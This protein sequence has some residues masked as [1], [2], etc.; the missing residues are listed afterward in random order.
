MAPIITCHNALTFMNLKR[1]QSR[2]TT[3]IIFS[4]FVCTAT[5][6]GER[7]ASRDTLS[8][9][10]P[11]A[12]SRIDIG[13]L[14]AAAVGPAQ[15]L[16]T[17]PGA[18]VLE[19]HVVAHGVGVAEAARARRQRAAWGGGGRGSVCGEMRARR[20]CAAQRLTARRASA[21]I[22]NAPPRYHR[23]PS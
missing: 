23:R 5:A 2:A 17:V 16:E 10:Q 15:R 21:G 4:R 3:K 19:P 9:S 7:R 18:A 8:V 20:R 12:T 22:C 11:Q 13:W 6:S 1:Y 14:G